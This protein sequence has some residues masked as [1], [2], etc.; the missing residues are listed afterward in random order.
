[1][2]KVKLTP[3]QQKFF[4][5]VIDLIQSDDDL[6]RFARAKASGKTTVLKEL[7]LYLSSKIVGC[8]IDG[9]FMPQ[10]MKIKLEKS[11]TENNLRWVLLSEKE[12]ESIKRWIIKLRQNEKRIKAK[13]RLWTR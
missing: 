6:L 3:T 5:A 11:Q 2:E 10:S 4:D 13:R 12:I 8:R 1:M 7:D 9:E